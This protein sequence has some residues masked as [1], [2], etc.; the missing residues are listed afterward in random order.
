MFEENPLGD[1]GL[2]R[3][4]YERYEKARIEKKLKDLILFKGYNSS[5]KLKDLDKLLIEYKKN[6]E[7]P[8]FRFDNETRN[9][10]DTFDK[11][12]KNSRDSLGGSS[13]SN[14]NNNLSSMNMFITHKEYILDTYSNV[15]LSASK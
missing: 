7:M 4:E 11:Y 14:Q 6:E 10:K 2:V 9:N 13:Q 15:T 3:L 8:K 1:D 5:N 12:E